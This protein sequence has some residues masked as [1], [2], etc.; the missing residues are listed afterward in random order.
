MFYLSIFLTQN[1]TLFLKSWFQSNN[2]FRIGNK[3]KATRRIFQFRSWCALY[4]EFVQQFRN[5]NLDFHQSKS[6]S[7]AN[8][9]EER[10]DRFNLVHRLTARCRTAW[11]K[12]RDHHWKTFVVEEGGGVWSKAIKHELMSFMDGPLHFIYK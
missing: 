5:E 9:I 10:I 2:N 3:K 8:S 1:V 11:K 4:L 6:L 12:W 7:N